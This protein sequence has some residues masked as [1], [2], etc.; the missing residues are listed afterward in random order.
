MC[1]SGQRG[2]LFLLQIIQLGSKSG[3]G[4]AGLFPLIAQVG[5]GRA[6]FNP[7]PA[8]AGVLQVLANGKGK[9][10]P[11]FWTHVGKN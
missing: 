4:E 6:T 3:Q 5:A 11:P 9:A 10:S 2:S 7:S 8:G 1:F